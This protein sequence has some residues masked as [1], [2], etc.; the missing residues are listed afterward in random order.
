GPGLLTISGN[1]GNREIRVA[2]KI[3]VTI[4]DNTVFNGPGGGIFDNFSEGKNTLIITNSTIAGNTASGNGGGFVFSGSLAAITFCTIYSN[5]ALDGGGIFIEDGKHAVGN[6][7][8]SHVQMQNSLV[9]RNH[10]SMGQ[11]IVGTLTTGGYN[12]I[13]NFT[14]VPFV[15]PMNK[16]A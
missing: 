11:D 14:W 10:Q 16:H 2:Q 7:V 8:P 9:A 12:L 13:Q 4:S 3:S 5:T 15:D 6:S 1:Q